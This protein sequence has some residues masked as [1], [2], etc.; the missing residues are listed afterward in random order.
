VPVGV[1]RSAAPAGAGYR[2]RTASCR[3]VP[4]PRLPP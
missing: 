3:I 2:G 4:A 1:T